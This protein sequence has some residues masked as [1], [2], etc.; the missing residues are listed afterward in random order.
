MRS[1]V[2]ARKSS[3]S[4]CS[5][6][7][8]KQDGPRRV[9]L[10]RVRQ[11][12]RPAAERQRGR[13]RG[14]QD[15]KKRSEPPCGGGNDGDDGSSSDLSSSS[16]LSHHSF[17]YHAST[18]YLSLSLTNQADYGAAAAAAANYGGG[19]EDDDEGEELDDDALD[20]A[21][22]AANAR[23][24]GTA[25]ASSP[26]PPASNAVV[27]HEDKRYYPSAQDVYGPGVET[28]A[29]EEDAQPI[30]VPI[31]A[32][33][34]TTKV[35]VGGV[36]GGGGRRLRE[37]AAEAAEDEEEDDGIGDRQYRF[38]PSIGVPRAD[39]RF[40]VALSA[41][42]SLVRSVAVLGALHCGKTSLVDTLVE[43]SHILPPRAERAESGGVGGGMGAHAPAAALQQRWG[44]LP[45]PRR[46]SD[47]RV[48]EQARG[49]S[50]KATPLS[51]VL[52]D[53][54]GKSMLINVVDAPG[55]VDFR[56]EA[57]AAMRLADGALLCV[58]AA[59][60]PTAAT[61]ALIAE[62]VR[63][64]LPISLV[65]TKVDRLITELKLPPKM[66]TTS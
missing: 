47:A 10:R 11:L 28:L 40:A 44:P 24:F 20:A 34:R 27:L 49:V 9:A 30:E 58:D 17:R 23:A 52:P 46:F 15:R 5:F 56:D 37:A 66:P 51:L 7:P 60:G 18:D 13:R 14:K 22:A 38:D 55:H 63:E 25:G 8:T 64:R 54:R 57:A 19:F 42:P 26:P 41:T 2:A 1:L 29:E 36:S 4:C 50:V 61:R 16:L 39:P 65:V 62:S 6:S 53:S 35:E 21:E 32:P 59:E 45:R 43:A 48:D 12:R 33:R 3:S 31:I